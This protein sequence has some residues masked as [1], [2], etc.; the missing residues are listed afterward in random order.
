MVPQS[1]GNFKE[2]PAEVQK[3]DLKLMEDPVDTL[4]ID[5]SSFRCTES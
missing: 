2:S 4:K 5:G 3:V 1:H